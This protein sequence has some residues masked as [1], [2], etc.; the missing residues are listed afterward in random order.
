MVL[1][2]ISE[3]VIIE[4]LGRFEFDAIPW[5]VPFESEYTHGKDLNTFF[6][7]NYAPFITDKQIEAFKKMEPVD[8][9]AVKNKEIFF[10][11]VK[12]PENE[13]VN[14]ASEE[15]KK[16]LLQAKKKHARLFLM[17]DEY[18]KHLF[19][20]YEFSAKSI[21]GLK[22]HLNKCKPVDPEKL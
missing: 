5:R 6:K 1:D 2:E 3:R 20:I 21:E 7:E 12:K 4:Y 14:F 10:F 8:I 22:I 16:S 9:I 11:L 17:T 13:T 15:E 19:N 18:P